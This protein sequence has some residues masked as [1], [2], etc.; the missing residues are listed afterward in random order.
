MPANSVRRMLF[1]NKMNT[2]LSLVVV[3]LPAA[4]ALQVIFES[5]ESDV[6]LGLYETELRVRKYN[7]T[8]TVVNGTF[9]WN[10]ALDDSIVVSS[11]EYEQIFSPISDVP[12]LTFA[13]GINGAFPQP[14]RQSTVQL[15]PD[16]NTDIRCMP[17]YEDYSR[18]ILRILVQH[19]Q[20]AAPGRMSDFA[21]ESIDP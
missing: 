2:F 18:R 7:R 6:G 4:L 5:V 11:A 21:S 20:H 13:T 3:V 12:L 10:A 16:E 15:L 1:S 9:S 14:T 17:V 19:C 8:I